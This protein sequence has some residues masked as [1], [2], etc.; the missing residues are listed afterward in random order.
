MWLLP[1]QFHQYLTVVS[2]STHI[3]SQVWNYKKRQGGKHWLGVERTK[4]N[5]D[6][7]RYLSKGGVWITKSNIKNVAYIKVNSK[8]PQNFK[9]QDLQVRIHIHMWT[10]SQTGGMP[11]EGLLQTSMPDT[12]ASHDIRSWNLPACSHSVSVCDCTHNFTWQHVWPVKSLKHY[13]Q[14]NY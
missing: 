1:L 9:M 4:Y 3:I 6:I 2:L 13:V 7:K 11:G 12:E 10:H 14:C 5:N 8:I